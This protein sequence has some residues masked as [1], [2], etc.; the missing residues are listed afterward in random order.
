M[1]T[2]SSLNMEDSELV[3]RIIARALGEGRNV[4]L[5][6]EAKAVCQAYRLPVPAFQVA[7]TQREA[8]EFAEK[9]GFPVVMKIISR[10][11]LHK[12]EAG[13]VLL[14]LNSTV[15]VENGYTSILSNA[16]A[17]K[18]NARVDGILVQH[19]AAT[20]TEIIV[21]GLRDLQFGPV[22]MFGLGGIFTEVLNDVTFRLAPIDERE[23]R[24]MIGEIRGHRLLAGFRGQPPA[25]E[26][27]V[28]STLVRVSMIMNENRS[29]AQ[30]DLNPIMVYRSG[31]SIVDA[32][33]LLRVQGQPITS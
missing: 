14:G 6:P 5:E 28:A 26:E 17:Y 19:M 12:T 21:G 15:D 30:I 10:D 24:E 11:I 16:K 3:D 8:V 13:G 31:C 7:T 2:T 20:G 4:L 23:A 27:A 25:D 1:S 18:S 22:V 32:R 33:I 29:I 9:V